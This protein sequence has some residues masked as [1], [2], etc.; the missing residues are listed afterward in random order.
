M[1]LVWFRLLVVQLALTIS[2][3][4]VLVGGRY[5]PRLTCSC[6]PSRTSTWWGSQPKGKSDLV[7]FALLITCE[8]LFFPTC[9]LPM[10][11]PDN[12]I[13]SIAC[14]SDIFLLLPPSWCAFASPLYFPS[15][16]WYYFEKLS[17][18]PII[19]SNYR[20]T[21]SQPIF[22]SSV[23]EPLVQFSSTLNIRLGSV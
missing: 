18:W 15:T 6:M 22:F 9:I 16:P 5:L 13:F 17:Y 2:R 3:L 21:I 7:I 4:S 23:F 8:F 12:R 10:S 11:P 14:A 1:S 19:Y 20:S